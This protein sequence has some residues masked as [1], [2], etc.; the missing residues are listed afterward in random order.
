ML[1]TI[2]LFALLQSDYSQDK[3][4]HKN[5]MT[6]EWQFVDENMVQFRLSTP[7]FGWS[8]IGINT[9]DGLVGSNLI[10]ASIKDDL[11]TISDRYVVAL[12]NHQAMSELGA[13]SK[14]VLIDAQ[15][16]DSGTEIIFQL[17]TRGDDGYHYE[18]Q[19]GKPIYLTMAYSRE[20]DFGHH[21]AMRTSTKIIL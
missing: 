5:G 11:T 6:V 19:E 2:I 10:M 17:D 15:E 16:S 1:I 4:I 3:S 8:A 20:D 18:L 14:V 13:E 12:G 21:S 7:S 9:Q